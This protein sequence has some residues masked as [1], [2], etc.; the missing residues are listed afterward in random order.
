[1]PI[2]ISLVAGPVRGW[3]TGVG[4][5]ETP[6]WA[7]SGLRL[8]IAAY[9]ARGYGI[10]T[11]DAAAA[12]QATREAAKG[13]G[14][15][16]RVFAVSKQA[17]PDTVCF[18]SLPHQIQRQAFDLVDELHPAKWLKPFVKQLHA[19]NSNQVLSEGLDDPSEL[20]VLWAM[21]SEFDDDGRLKNVA[22]GTGQAVRVAHKFN[23]RALNLDLPD[24]RAQLER[25]LGIELP[26]PPADECEEDLSP[27]ARLF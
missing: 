22:G 14:A 21:K 15:P 13:A 9:A 11:G 20:V 17:C 16:L 25:E 4:S 19:R 3:I 7:M 1:V 12:D 23:V 5:R 27:Q 2:H 26:A 10:R 18:T 8:V 6:D 24:H